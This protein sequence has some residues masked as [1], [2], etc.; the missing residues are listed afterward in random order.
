MIR[1]LTESGDFYLGTKERWAEYRQ[2]IDEGNW[3]LV[4]NME[5]GEVDG[6]EYD[7]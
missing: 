7:P 1:D 3:E 6:F 5:T 4:E 2:A